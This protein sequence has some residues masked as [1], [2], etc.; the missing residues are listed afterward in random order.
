MNTRRGII[1]GGNWIVDHVKTIDSW[2]LQDTLA[3]ILGEVRGNGGSPYNVLK[4][5]AKLG[6]DFPLEAVGL[7]GDDENG[8]YILEDCSM[9]GINCAQLR[10][11]REAPTSYT[12]VMTVQTG[13]RRTFFNQRG[14][15]AHLEPAHFDFRSTRASH[16]HISYALLLDRLDFPG[17]GGLPRIAEVLRTARK[18]GMSTSLDCVSEHSDR[19]DSVVLPTLP[20]VDVLFVNDFETEKLAHRPLRKRDALIPQEVETAGR[21]LLGQGVRKAV[22]IHFPEGACACVN[23]CAPIWQ[24]SVQLPSEK[25]AGAAGAGDAFAAGV[26]LALLNEE[27][28]ERALN[29]GV[30]AAAVSMLD[31]TCSGSIKPAAACLEMGRR[32]SFRA[33]PPRGGK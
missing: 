3:N 13:G 1:A 23:E 32:Y 17:P 28:W 2:P 16:C 9:H 4:N 10:T 19:F 25:I 22:V 6:A 8:R 18:F 12:D 31:P 11:T 21:I 26:L 7:V 15:N 5:L 30:C 14:A 27:P 20:E 33:L 29:L 24:A